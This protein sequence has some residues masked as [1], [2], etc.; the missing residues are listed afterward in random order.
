LKWQAASGQEAVERVRSA[1]DLVE[2]VAEYVHLKKAGANFKGLCPSHQ[3]HSPSF[4]VNPA[5]Q[6]FY[7][8]GCG[9]GGDVFSFL[10]KLEGLTFS[11]SLQTLARRAGVELKVSEKT[12]G[13][14]REKEELF[15][16]H[17]WAGRWYR[18]VLMESPAGATIREYLVRRGVGPEMSERF[19]LG[20]ALP[21]RDAFLEEA[22]KAGF[23]ASLLVRSGLVVQREDGGLHDRFRDRLMFP[24]HDSQ[25][26]IA[27]FGGRAMGDGQPKY[28]NSP[29]TPLYQKGALLYGWPFARTAAAKEGAVVVV[30]GYMDVVVLHQCGLTNV[31]ASLGTS[32]TEGQAVMIKRYVELCYLAFDR[33][34][35]G[36]QASSRGAETLIEQGLYVKVVP[37]P[38]GQDPD[39]A[40]LKHGVGAWAQWIASAPPFIETLI[41]HE[42]HSLDQK[43]DAVRKVLPYLAKVKNEIE[44]AE[45]VKWLAS[46]IHTEERFIWKELRQIGSA[47]PSVRVLTFTPPTASSA[48]RRSQGLA[49]YDTEQ[50]MLKLLWEDTDF[51][52]A[53]KAE[54]GSSAFLEPSHREAAEWCFRLMESGTSLTIDALRQLGGP[55]AVV[56]TL[57][58]LSFVEYPAVAME[59]LRAEFLKVVRM[60]R[61]RTRRDELKRHIEAARGEGRTIDLEM[62]REFNE[63]TRQLKGSK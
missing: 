47:S 11:E 8:F 61:L 48:P 7:C 59:T 33:D 23:P 3:E 54:G 9:A 20:Y 43:L 15:K 55:D 35:A 10:M 26:R 31:V 58:Q 37:L 30:E 62:I 13:A 14:W 46:K 50:Q 4:M 60:R 44:K 42:V 6:L 29:E 56:Q 38:E 5:K 19:G 24:I 36:H 45:Y 40:V 49:G 25:S 34:T 52:D 12:S 39:E 22:L 53:L 51:A 1:V 2:L 16:L 63:I 27:A 17:E 32:L 21:A 57:S 18:R 41:P 28:L